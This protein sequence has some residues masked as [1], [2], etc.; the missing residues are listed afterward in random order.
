MPAMN[1]R[2][3]QVEKDLA[4]RAK[5]PEDSGCALESYQSASLRSHRPFLMGMREQIMEIGR[6]SILS[7]S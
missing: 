3:E 1:A 6:L 5:E 2:R 4:Q 7:I